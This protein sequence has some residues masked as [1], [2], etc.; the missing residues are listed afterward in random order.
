MNYSYF[1]IILWILTHSNI[2]GMQK[3]SDQRLQRLESDYQKNKEHLFTASG[4][5][6]AQKML[7]ALNSIKLRFKVH[8]P[9]IFELEEKLSLACDVSRLLKFHANH[10]SPITQHEL[11]ELVDIFSNLNQP[12]LKAEAPS[13]KMLPAGHSLKTVSAF[14]KLKNLSPNIDLR[15]DALVLYESDADGNSLV[16][17]A[18]QKNKFAAIDSLLSLEQRLIDESQA[19]FNYLSERE[20]KYQRIA[21]RYNP[22]TDTEKKPS[23]VTII[24]TEPFDLLLEQRNKAGQTPLVFAA[25]LNNSNALLHVVNHN[26][27]PNA[28][29]QQ[30]KTALHYA[31]QLKNHHMLGILFTQKGILDNR[32]D[33]EGY[34]PF[35]RLLSSHKFTT[36]DND[37]CLC[38]AMFKTH[39]ASLY[40]LKDDQR[41]QL[42]LSI[43]LQPSSTK[44][45]SQSAAKNKASKSNKKKRAPKTQQTLTV[46]QT[47]PTP[48]STF[49]QMI[50]MAQINKLKKHIDI[51][52]SKID[53]DFEDETT[54]HPILRAVEMNNCQLVDTLM[55]YGSNINYKPRH[56]KQHP[57][58]ALRAHE[59][60]SGPLLHYAYLISIYQ[61]NT[62]EELIRYK[63]ANLDARNSNGET[64]LGLILRKDQRNMAL[65]KN[66]LY[67]KA[68]YINDKKV[69]KDAQEQKQVRRAIGN[70]T[71]R[72][73]YDEK[74]GRLHFDYPTKH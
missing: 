60:E 53:M 43:N 63:D 61:T 9:A 49:N 51:C 24:P 32:I 48:Q 28:Q 42:V 20:K 4:G 55:A 45:K 21:F 40:K 17:V 52:A 74:E 58:L 71:L 59:F 37:L 8:T 54:L 11:Y 64:L 66:L 70:G 50:G 67:V 47:E 18:V 68:E 6:K 39:H 16:H 27:N 29:D 72:I 5:D 15:N 14:N 1:L 73:N 65:V 46:A 35:D 2:T 62:F 22:E 13:V 19:D 26:P 12:L 34:N 31:A 25:S 69:Y 41:A 33:A 56:I 36:S 57:M 30:G 38:L 44:K 7:H 10:Q 23:E 3:S